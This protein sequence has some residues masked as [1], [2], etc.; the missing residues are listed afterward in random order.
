MTSFCSLM[1]TMACLCVSFRASAD[2]MTPKL[3]SMS[4]CQSLFFILLRLN[5]VLKEW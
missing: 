2:S 4:L 1:L 5:S 3:M